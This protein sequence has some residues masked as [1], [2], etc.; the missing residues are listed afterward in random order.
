MKQQRLIA[1][2][3]VSTSKQTDSGLG[4][5]GQSAE[6]ERASAYHWWDV[7]D[8]YTDVSTSGSRGTERPQ[9]DA[10]IERIE[11]GEADG[12]VVQ[13]LDR[14]SRSVLDFATLVARANDNGWNL[15][16]IDRNLDLT[17]PTGR[18]TASILSAV[19]ELEREMTRDRT[20]RALAAAK[21]RGVQLGRPKEVDDTVVAR[22]KAAREHGRQYKD[23][24]ADL[25]ADG[26][27]APRGGTRWHMTTVARI[28]KAAA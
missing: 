28:A 12:L 5:E 16:V 6:I 18:F 13:A 21:A 11:R 15:I 14:V 23:I 17:T 19:A 4:L 2:R 25:Q 7:I 1:Y 10:A 24:V 22:I 8:T 9:L 3:R 20:V 27:P 26:V